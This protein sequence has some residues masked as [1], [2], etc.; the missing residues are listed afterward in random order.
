MWPPHCGLLASHSV[1]QTGATNRANGD[2]GNRTRVRGRVQ[3]G[4]Y[5]RSRLSVSRLPLASPAGVRET[6]P[7]DVPAPP[8]ALGAGLGRLLMAARSPTGRGEGGISSS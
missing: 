1:Q 7:L 6:S 2:A 8:M 5:E 3:D 4:F